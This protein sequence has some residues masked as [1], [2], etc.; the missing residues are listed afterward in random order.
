MSLPPATLPAPSPIPIAFANPDEG[1]AICC[2]AQVAYAC[3]TS[4]A[5]L[6]CSGFDLESC[7]SACAPSDSSCTLRCRDEAAH[8]RPDPSA[9]TRDQSRDRICIVR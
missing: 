4:E 7:L 3:D 8:I 9:C 2:V 5:L 6:A 1:G